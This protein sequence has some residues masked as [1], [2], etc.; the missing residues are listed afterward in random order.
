MIYVGLGPV[1]LVGRLAFPLEFMIYG[2]LPAWL[3]AGNYRNFGS[4]R[5][6]LLQKHVNSSCRNFLV[7]F[8]CMKLAWSL[9][10]IL[11]LLSCSHVGLEINQGLAWILLAESF[12]ELQKIVEWK[13]QEGTRKVPNFLCVARTC[14]ISFFSCGLVGLWLSLV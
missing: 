10:R 6:P 5:K 14:M 12:L 7:F 11:L 3:K 13:A 2:C 8:C 1:E 4:C 9:P